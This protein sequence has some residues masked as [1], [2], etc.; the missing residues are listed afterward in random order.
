MAIEVCHCGHVDEEHGG[1]D[2]FPG[3]TECGADDCDC[4][5][6]EW[7]GTKEEVDA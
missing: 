1:N 5:C 6:F 4:V 2:E 7:D 3:S